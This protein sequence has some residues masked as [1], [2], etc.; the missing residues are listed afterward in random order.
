M[1][2]RTDLKINGEHAAL[3]QELSMAEFKGYTI[4]ELEGIKNLIK[5]MKQDYLRESGEFRSSCLIHRQEIFGKI[6]D[7]EKDIK[8][9]SYFRAQVLA[10]SGVLSIIA[11]SI[12]SWFLR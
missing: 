10:L 3:G 2:N 1:W 8:S 11:G 12:V 7:N 5:D 9:L 4:A 6:S